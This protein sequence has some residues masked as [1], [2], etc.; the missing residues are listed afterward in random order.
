MPDA[1]RWA[2]TRAVEP[3]TDPAVWTRS[4]GLPTAPS[5]GARYSSGIMLPSNMSGALP[6]TTASM[7]DHVSWASA[8][9]DL[10]ASRTMPAIETS[11]RLAFR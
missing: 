5:A 10:A 8:R 7:S 11:S 3:P 1:I 9:A 4:M 6:M 2:A